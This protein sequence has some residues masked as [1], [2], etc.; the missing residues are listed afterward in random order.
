MTT[1]LVVL[2]PREIPEVKICLDRIQDR[3]IFLQRYWEN[4]LDFAL[5]HAIDQTDD[6]FYVVVSDDVIVSQDALDAVKHVLQFHPHDFVTGY[7]NLDAL[8]GRAGL[9]KEP[10]RGDVPVAE[11]YEWYTFDEIAEKKSGST[12]RTWFTPMCLT[13]AHR[14]T[15]LQY[16]LEAFPSAGGGWCATDFV[17]SKKLERDDVPV[18][19]VVDALC[20]HLKVDAEI[21]DNFDS[22][23]KALKHGL[24]ETRT[25]IET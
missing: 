14:D 6:D 3:K 18:W 17:L 2:N 10:L 12:F 1:N 19:A 22:G 25:V 15:W 24:L 5:R 20:W 4:Q 7:C 21:S 9:V 16:G 8:S 11:A 23:R 13:G